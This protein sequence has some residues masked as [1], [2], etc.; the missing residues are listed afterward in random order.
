MMTALSGWPR[1][2]LVAAALAAAPAAA[3]VLV[4]DHANLIDGIGD[5][6]LRDVT[7]VIRDKRIAS[8]GRDA[9]DIPAGARRINLAGRWVMPGM[10]DAHVHPSGIGDARNMLAA[11]VTTGRSML[12]MHF[13]DAGIAALHRGGATDLPDILPAGYPIVP[14]PSDFVPDLGGIFLDTPALADLR[15]RPLDDEGIRR[16]VRANIARGATVIK[17][18]ATDRAGVL[19]SDP[20]RP[21]LNEAQLVVAVTEA[22]AGGARVAAHAHGDAGAAAAVRAGVDTID[23]GVYVSEATLAL[24]KQR[25][26]C[27]VPT[28]EIIAMD[29][30]H[31]AGVPAGRTIRSRAMTPQSLAT[32]RSALA[33]GVRVV[34]GTDSSYGSD[35]YLR[36]GDELDRLRAA[37]M[38]PMQVLRAAT[39]ASADCVGIGDRTGRVRPGYEADLIVLDRNPLDDTAAVRDVGL[40]INDGSVA[41]DRGF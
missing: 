14:N 41:I 1:R 20:R 2:L 39:S 24:M 15:G 12:T 33:L 32:V 22:R 40:V 6:P 16:I 19:S 11:G 31:E 21:M 18:F 25:G 4:L 23:H 34:A 3:Q 5:Q 17:V 37:G 7:I 38:T 35:N 10:I 29:I 36:I 30:N 26:T 28:M 8:V 27:L 9:A 13:V